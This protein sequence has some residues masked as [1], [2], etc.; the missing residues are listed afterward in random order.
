MLLT[1]LIARIGS[2]IKELVNCKVYKLSLILLIDG[3]FP[4][5]FNSVAS[6]ETE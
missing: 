3:N 2:I 4:L 5:Q 6:L 1:S